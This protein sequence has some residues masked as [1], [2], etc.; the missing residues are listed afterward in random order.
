I[1]KGFSN[2]IYATP[3]TRDLCE[4]MLADSAYIHEQDAKYLAKK[5]WPKPKPL[6]TKEDA[7]ATMPFFQT[8]KY[9]E[10]FEPI[11]GVKVRFI[12]AGHIL[13]AAQ[14]EIEFSEGGKTRRIG[15]TGDLGRK[16]LPILRDPAQF[17]NLDVLITESTYAN[18]LHDDIKE[19]E[20]KMLA[21]VEKTA[22]RGGKIIIPAFSVERTQE[23]VYVLHDLH[24][25][26]KLK[27]NL[28][29]FVDSPLAVNATDI[30]KKHREC[31]DTETYEDFIEK[32]K[33]PFTMQSLEYVRDVERSK[34]LNTIHYPVI[35]ISAS[36]MCEAGRI[37]HHLR[38]NIS[39]PKNTVLIVGFQA[40]NTLGRRLV[41]KVPEVR[42]FG[43]P[44]DRKCEVDI[45][46]AFSAHADRDELFA[47][48]K[49]SAASKV[50]CVHGEPES[51]EFLAERARAELQIEAIVPEEGK[52]FEI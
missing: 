35:I 16:N 32:G 51:V 44:V 1:K 52:E 37:R 27:L 34:E 10:V 43:E 13:G 24:A 31:Y 5:V 3:A 15:F 40:E 29:I 25:S 7:A 17:Q 22:K 19:V 30:F 47:N 36:G 49:S 4:I 45:L 48:I 2:P 33:G 50:V 21:I 12:D 9:N 23:I 11:E 18:R 38:N 6:Y 39:D 28:P 41:E 8:K 42:I 20:E 14:V 46:N 26:G